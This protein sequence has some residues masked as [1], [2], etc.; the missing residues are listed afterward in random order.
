MTYRIIYSCGCEKQV[1]TTLTQHKG[2]LIR[3]HE[4]CPVC[5]LKEIQRDSSFVM[6]QEELAL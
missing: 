4:K 6:I 5:K 1:D 3:N 2:M